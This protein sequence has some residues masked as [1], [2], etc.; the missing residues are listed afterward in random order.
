MRQRTW[1]DGWARDDLVDDGTARRITPEMM[2]R[3]YTS[4]PAYQRDMAMLSKVGW[5]VTS[6]LE[7]HPHGLRASVRAWWHR[8]RGHPDSIVTVSYRR[9]H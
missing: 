6:V 4:A 9:L 8:T 1:R 2:T 3:E 7:H 5:R